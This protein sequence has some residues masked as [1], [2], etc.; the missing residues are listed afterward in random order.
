M[1][2][3]QGFGIVMAVSPGVKG[4]MSSA[5]DIVLSGHVVSQYQRACAVN[6]SFS[7]PWAGA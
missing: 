2:F 4:G 6:A 5:A 3:H 7:L 1:A